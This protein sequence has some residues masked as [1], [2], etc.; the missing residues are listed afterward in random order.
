VAVTGKFVGGFTSARLQ[1]VDRRQSAVLAV[2]MNTRGLTELVVFSIGVELGALDHD[3]YSAMVLMAL[4][5]TAITSPILRMLS[6][7]Q[8]TGTNPADLLTATSHVDVDARK[9]WR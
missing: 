8:H 3:L 4:I 1:G 9:A 5:T 2:L 7:R 6:P